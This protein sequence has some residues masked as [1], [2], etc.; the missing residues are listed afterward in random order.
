LRPRPQRDSAAGAS[1][2]GHSG[3]PLTGMYGYSRNAG[4]AEIL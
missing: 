4:G 2:C 3:C 1:G